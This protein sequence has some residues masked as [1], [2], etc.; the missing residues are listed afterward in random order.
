MSRYNQLQSKKYKLIKKMSNESPTSV[1]YSLI[2]PNGFP[3][4]L[5]LRDEKMGILMTNMGLLETSL[6]SKGFTPQIK[7]TFGEKK[8]I[9]YVQGEVC[10]KCGKPLIVVNNDKMISKCSDNK[11]NPVTKKGEPCDYVKWRENK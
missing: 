3:L 11:Y 8:P 10:P 9:E 4:L 2:S 1:T 6:K 5:T 7:K